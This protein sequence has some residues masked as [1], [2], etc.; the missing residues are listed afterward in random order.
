MKTLKKHTEGKPNKRVLLGV[1][2]TIIFSF[3]SYIFIKVLIELIMIY[4]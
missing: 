3:L 2:G 4:L 1:L